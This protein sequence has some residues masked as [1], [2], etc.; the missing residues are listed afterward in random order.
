VSQIPLPCLHKS[1]DL[2]MPCSYVLIPPLYSNSV[3]LLN[4]R[5]C[6]GCLSW[7][8]KSLSVCMCVCLSMDTFVV[9]FP[10]GFG[11]N[12][13]QS[14][15]MMPTKKIG[16]NFPVRWFWRVMALDTCFCDNLSPQIRLICL[17]PRTFQDSYN[18]KSCSKYR[19]EHCVKIAA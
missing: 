3:P 8:V 4:F 16:E 2:N 11:W 12:L 10:N 13:A 19:M 5:N 1:V 9:T 18:N 15:I 14:K 6:V 7:F 17:K